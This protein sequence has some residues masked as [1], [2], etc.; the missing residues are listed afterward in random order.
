MHIKYGEIG[1]SVLHIIMSAF[2]F[3]IA[4][5]NTELLEWWFTTRLSGVVKLLAF[6]NSLK[7]VWEP[8]KAPNNNLGLGGMKLFGN[9]GGIGGNCTP[10]MGWLLEWLYTGE[11]SLALELLA[12]D[13][14]IPLAC[15]SSSLSAY[16]IAWIVRRILTSYLYG[17]LKMIQ[18]VCL[19]FLWYS[20][21]SIGT[22][23]WA[24]SMGKPVR[25]KKMSTYFSHRSKSRQIKHKQK[26]NSSSSL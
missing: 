21:N 19:W 6:I 3:N 15:F 18:L 24:F 10:F 20:G 26:M 7:K 17:L 13:P 9:M 4:C 14:F 8:Q 1:R 5:V 25:R 22:I 2:Y 11:N 23:R 12:L 16:L